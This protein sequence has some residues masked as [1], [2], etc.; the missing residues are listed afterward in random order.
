MAMTP[1]TGIEISQ[2]KWQDIYMGLPNSPHWDLVG[3]G[4]FGKVYRAR[5]KATGKEDAVK[6]IPMNEN[7]GLE[8]VKREVSILKDCDS[9]HIVSY[10]GCY[11]T[12]TELWISMEFC[13]GGSVEQITSTTEEPLREDQIARV[14]SEALK[15]LQYLHQHS[16]IHRDVKGGNILLTDSGQVKL[17]DFG[18]SAQLATTLSQRN[19]FVGT[20]YWMA[21]EVILERQYDGRAD[22]WSLGITAIEMAELAPPHHNLHPMRA[23]FQIPKGPPPTLSK[24]GNWSTEFDDFVRACLVKDSNLRL[25]A[26]QALKLPFLE[27]EGGTACLLEAIETWK[28]ALSANEIEKQKAKEREKEQNLA[29]RASAKAAVHDTSEG[30]DT[31]NT[32]DHSRTSDDH[33]DA[34]FVENISD[35]SGTFIDNDDNSLVD[36]DMNDFNM[37]VTDAAAAAYFRKTGKSASNVD[38]C[39]SPMSLA[40]H[41][42]QLSQKEHLERGEILDLPYIK[43]DDLSPSVLLAPLKPSLASNRGI[44]PSE[45]YRIV[46]EDEGLESLPRSSP[47]T[48]TPTVG[49]ILREFTNRDVSART[50]SA[51]RDDLEYVLKTICA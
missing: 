10:R 42:T 41:N 51:F 27:Q 7:E 32:V 34:T 3:R 28:A 16:K 26:W 23:L 50:E 45:L 43:L 13:G 35:E 24:R 33:S 48:V 4:S 46:A 44:D 47:V 19:T 21:P 38:S 37:A 20:T 9:P 22:I 5:R 17:A 8:D 11:F 2:G 1:P 49:S 31:T 25:Q 30:V 12:G 15:G 36:N 18:V 6:V 39:L 14:C 40:A 29:K